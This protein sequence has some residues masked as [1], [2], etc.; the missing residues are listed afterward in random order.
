M[1]VFTFRTVM[2]RGARLRGAQSR[3]RPSSRGDLDVVARRG[4]N[5]GRGRDR[6][7]APLVPIHRAREL[8]ATRRDQTRREVADVD[9]RA[10]RVV[11]AA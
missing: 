4:R 6:D 3:D 11:A 2:V 8:T 1:S 9:P 5:V 10:V 7:V